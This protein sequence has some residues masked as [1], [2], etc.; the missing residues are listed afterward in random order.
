VTARQHAVHTNLGPSAARMFA[1]NDRMNQI[2]IEHLDP[3]AWRAKPPGKKCCAICSLTR[4]TIAGR[5]VCLRINSD[6]PCQAK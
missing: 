3:G 2:L 5:F 6:S 4:P 1:A